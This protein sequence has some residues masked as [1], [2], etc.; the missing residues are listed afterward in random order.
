MTPVYPDPVN[1][2]ASATNGFQD[3]YEL[4]QLSP[5]ADSYT[6][7]RVYRVLV[8]RYHP[9]N[10]DTGNPD[11]FRE[12]VDAYRVLSDPEQRAAYDAKYDENR[13]FVFGIFE[14]A[15]AFDNFD[16]DRRIFEGILSLLYA[17]RR[18]EP[19]RGGVGVIQLERLLA[20]P[21]E[22]LEFHVWYLLEKHW[23]SRQNNGQLAITVA[24]IDHMR[25]Q[26][27]R[28][29][30]RD[31]LIPDTNRPHFSRGFEAARFRQHDLP[32]RR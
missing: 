27:A 18:R 2:A 4:L 15:S 17:A 10:Q 32:A 1:T 3:F 20:C 8:K 24:G 6:L 14:E 30:Q 7:S 11:K 16:T 12:I 19:S 29:L 22:H 13:T 5:N 25:E 31:H 23:I 9:D 21:A 26:T 28:S